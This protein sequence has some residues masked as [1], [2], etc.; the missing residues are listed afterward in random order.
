M[1]PRTTP[2]IDLQEAWNLVQEFQA[3]VNTLAMGFS[4]QE[5]QV[6]VSWWG[7]DGQCEDSVDY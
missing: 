7:E 3:L 1:T 5:A 2:T 4:A 6:G